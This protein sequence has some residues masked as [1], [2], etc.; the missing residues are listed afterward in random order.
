M[1]GIDDL[2]V[3]TGKINIV[4][5]LKD[6]TPL[7]KRMSIWV[8]IYVNNDHYQS[9]PVWFAVT[10]RAPVLVMT[11]EANKQYFANDVV[12]ITAIKGRP[13]NE[14]QIENTRFRRELEIGDAITDVAVE[15]LP[16]VIK[17]AQVIVQA[18][19]GN[20]I[21]KS[22]AVAMK[23]GMPGDKIKVRKPDSQ[24][25]YVVEVI[26]KNLVTADKEL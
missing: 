26:G 4:P 18:S 20:V 19:A 3:P 5:V 15:K 1:G 17:G 23:D 21:V 11:R 22:V 2:Y 16:N 24:I 12:D 7:N 8:D 10:V 6:N 25:E 13:V 14:A 9:I